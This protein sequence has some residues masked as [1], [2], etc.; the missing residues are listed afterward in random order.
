MLKLPRPLVPTLALIVLA[1]TTAPLMW[2]SPP[3]CIAAVLPAVM[4]VLA[5]LVSAPL[6]LPWPLEADALKPTAP[7]VTL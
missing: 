5:Q 4:W 1:A 2:V 6:L 3:L 7:V